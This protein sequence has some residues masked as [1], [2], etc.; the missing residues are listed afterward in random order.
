LDLI[1][2]KPNVENTPAILSGLTQAVLKS[3]KSFNFTSTNM[4]L[5][6]NTYSTSS[7]TSLNISTVDTSVSAVIPSVV[8]DSE[9]VAVSLSVLTDNPLPLGDA[10]SPMGGVV[11]LSVFSNGD[12]LSVRNTSQPIRIHMGFISSFSIINDTVA[13]YYWHETGST[14]KRDGCVLVTDSVSVYCE[15]NHLTNFTLGYSSR[16]TRDRPV[17]DKPT[18]TST[19]TST[20]TTLII[21]ICVVA[22]GVLLLALGSVFIYRRTGLSRMKRQSNVMMEMKSTIVGEV[23]YTEKIK[24]GNVEVWKGVYNGTNIVAVKKTA[25]K[26]IMSRLIREANN[27]KEMHHPNVI[28]FLGQDLSSTEIYIVSEWMTDGTLT[29][30]MKIHQMSVDAMINIGGQI[31]NAMSYI[32]E[33]GMVHTRVTSD[34]ILLSVGEY[35]TTAKLGGLSSVVVLGS[36]VDSKSFG[37]HTAPEVVREGIQTVQGDVWSFGVLLHK[38]ASQGKPVYP[39]LTPKEV[40]HHLK[41]NDV[42]IEMDNS[43]N[44]SITACIREC[45]KKDPFYRPN[46]TTIASRLSRI[47]THVAPHNTYDKDTYAISDV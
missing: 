18:P 40:I 47:N 44:N 42:T 35:E 16:T 33:R 3:A 6:L 14:W 26:K 11:G 20:P 5:I 22:A 25:D 34:K 30:F 1:S 12:L 17:S 46:F 37:S 15:C 2:T 19:S 28:M 29:Q 43:W 8:L 9:V 4:T 32:S 27:M 41:T 24:G 36:A 23:S 10:F 38:M 21:I 7:D 45:T 13:C 39:G 31:A